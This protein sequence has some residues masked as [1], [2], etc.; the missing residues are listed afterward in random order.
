MTTSRPASALGRRPFALGP[1]IKLP[2][3]VTEKPRLFGSILVAFYIFLITGRILDVS[4]IWWLHIP[5]LLLIT[6]TVSMMSRGDFTYTFQSKMTKYFGAFTLW[7]FVCLPFS[8]WRAASMGSVQFQAQAFLI[9]LIVVQVV[10]T[11]ADWV[12]IAGAYAYAILVAALLTFYIGVSVQ[13]RVSLPNGTLGDPNEFALHM[14]TGLP[15]WWFKASR[16]T[17]FRKVF[18]LL[19]TIPIYLAFARAGSRAGLL[20]LGILLLLTFLFA[21]GGKKVLLC[22]LAVVGVAAS[23]F[24]LPGYLKARFT[25]VFSPA[26]GNFDA[27]TQSRIESDIASSEERKALLMQSLSMTIHHPIV[28]IGPGTFSFVSRDERIANGQPG[29]ENLVTHN[30]YTQTSS[31]TGLPGFF[32][33]AATVVTAVR[34]AYS[35]YHRHSVGNRELA[36]AARYLLTALGGLS[37]GIFF[38]SVGY[39]H[40]LGVLFALSLAL[41]RVAGNSKQ[42]AELAATSVVPLGRSFPKIRFQAQTQLLNRSF[43]PRSSGRPRN[44]QLT[45]PQSKRPN[46]LET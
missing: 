27:A 29:G 6:L 32:F 12:K 1:E 26:S 31:E 30:T 38:L 2:D 14:V 8:S 36:L 11:E 10:R 22:V 18:F 34:Y 23:S 19:C 3:L 40:L 21:E 33:F 42:T 39:T 15:F 20:A 17:G 24:V 35:D 7:V 46:P 37:V 25:T 43:T 28:G 16:A 13:G 9:F 41:H 45:Q 5:L 44:Q 4:P